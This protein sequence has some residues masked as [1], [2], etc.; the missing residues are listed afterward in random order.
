MPPEAQA[1][2]EQGVSRPRGGTTQ[3]TNR[4]NK[5]LRGKTQEDQDLPTTKNQKAPQEPAKAAIP[6]ETGQEGKEKEKGKKKGKDCPQLIYAALR[7]TKSNKT[8]NSTTNS[9]D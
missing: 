2:K 4:S 3:E 5:R 6:E 9:L 1:K 8:Y 7:Y